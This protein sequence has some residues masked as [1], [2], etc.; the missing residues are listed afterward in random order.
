VNETL[1]A[2]TQ[3]FTPQMPVSEARVILDR[4]LRPLWRIDPS[5]ELYSSALSVKARY[6]FSFYDSLIVAAALEADCERLLSEDLQHGQRI[7][8]LTIVNPFIGA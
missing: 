1:N 6:Q 8:G 3:K 5:T 2:L 7:E 4:T